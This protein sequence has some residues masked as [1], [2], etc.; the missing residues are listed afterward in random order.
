ME[1]R[2][3]IEF[4]NK[5]TFSLYGEDFFGDKS[6]FWNSH[7]SSLN[8]LYRKVVSSDF[9]IK[10][11]DLT[12]KDPLLISTLTE[13][14][15]WLKENQPFSDTLKKIDDR[16]ELIYSEILE[17]CN[18][19]NSYEFEYYWEIWGIMWYPWTIEINEEFQTF[20]LNDISDY[21]LTELV[22]LEKIELIKTYDKSE[23]NDEFDRKRYRIS[24]R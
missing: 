7:Q 21:D 2:Y 6:T 8:D 22:K 23:M 1:F 4:K 11:I 13:F 24:R 5:D 14:R 18:K 12:T 19:E 10:L 3:L 20:S 9:P 15:E 17:K 16:N